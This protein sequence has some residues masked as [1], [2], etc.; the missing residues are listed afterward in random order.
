MPSV[1]TS[2]LVQT[3]VLWELSSKDNYNR[4]VVGVGEDIPVRW[5]KNRGESK[6]SEGDAQSKTVTVIVCQ[7]IP[8][9]SLLWLGSLNDIVGTA[10]PSTNLYIVTDYSETP[11]LKGRNFRRSV[12]AMRYT[13]LFPTVE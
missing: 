12:Q 8:I 2:D 5:L 7:S 9:G 13:D 11:D 1:E 4:P 10:L 3:A 6:S